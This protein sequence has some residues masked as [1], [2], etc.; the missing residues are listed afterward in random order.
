MEIIPFDKEKLKD[1]TYDGIESKVSGE[2]SGEMIVDIA[3]FYSSLGRGYIGLID[4]EVIG[5]GGVHPLWKDWGS[6]WL[7]LNKEA[8]NHVNGVFKGMLAKMN[9]LIKLYNIEILS[10]QCLDNS[11]EAN[12]LLNHLGF[13][14]S[15]EFKMALYGRKVI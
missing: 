11:L 12:K 15:R 8:K 4:G 5:I 13:V 6:A 3:Q 1:F 10:V 2:M 14:K 7:F 9:E